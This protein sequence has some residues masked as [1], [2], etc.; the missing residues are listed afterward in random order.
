MYMLPTEMVTITNADDVTAGTLATL[1]ETFEYAVSILPLVISVAVILIFL[2]LILK[3][4]NRK[5]LSEAAFIF[6][7]CLFVISIVGFYYAMSEMTKV[8]VGGITGSKSLEVAIPGKETFET[9]SCNWGPDIG[10][11]LLLISTV[12]VLSVT[13]WEIK[14]FLQKKKKPATK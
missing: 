2:S 10:F 12:I 8:I 6:S 5:K 13:I 7:N 9:L 3:K 11:Y 1:E 4:Y 14:I